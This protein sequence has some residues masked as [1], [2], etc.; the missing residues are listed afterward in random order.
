MGSGEVYAG[1]TPFRE[2]DTI[3]SGQEVGRVLESKWE[4]G[5]DSKDRAGYIRLKGD[6]D[7][8]G[9]Y[10]VMK[11]PGLAGAVT[12]TQLSKTWEVYDVMGGG[13]VNEW[14]VVGD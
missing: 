14:T 8:R 3:Y 7:P 10:K 13:I 1:L 4:I 9:E 6:F 2:A 11:Y 12:Q 5:G